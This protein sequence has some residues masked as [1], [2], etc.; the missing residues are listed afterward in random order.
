MVR[1]AISISS[2]KKTMFLC[3]FIG[4]SPIDSIKYLYNSKSKI[5]IEQN[6]RGEHK[7]P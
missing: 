5:S 6:V 1:L 4:I 2:V 3:L 7:H